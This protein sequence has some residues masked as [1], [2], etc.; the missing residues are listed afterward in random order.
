MI[1]LMIMS[2]FRAAD[3][4]MASGFFCYDEMVKKDK[5][6]LLGWLVGWMMF[7]L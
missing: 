5:V 4:P 6:R 1:Q 2:Y 7:S 3:L